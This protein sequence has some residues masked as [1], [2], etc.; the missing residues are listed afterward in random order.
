MKKILVK[1]GEKITRNVVE[2]VY[3]DTSFVQR[4]SG[5]ERALYKITSPCAIHL[6]QWILNKMNK[7]NT[8]SLTKAE[9]LIFSIES[10][11]GYSLSAINKSLKSLVDT[12][13]VFSTNESTEKEG[14]IIKSRNSM[15]YVN[16]KF[17]WKNPSKQSRIEMI[18]IL[19]EE[20]LWNR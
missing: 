11:R 3:I 8:F 4:Y 18:K 20:K 14:K 9:K 1:T 6:L 12:D 2:N 15:Y 19:E 16:P 7:H 5:V 13:I 10:K 17:Y